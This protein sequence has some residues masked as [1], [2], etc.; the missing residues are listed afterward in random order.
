MPKTKAE[1]ENNLPQQIIAEDTGAS[2]AGKDQKGGAVYIEN[3]ASYVMRGGTIAGMTKT[4]GGAVYIASGSTFTMEAGTITGCQAKYGGAIYVA[5]GGTCNINGGTIS[6]N[7]A[8]VGP[9][10]YVEN[11]G[12]LNVSEEAVIENNEYA[13][14][15]VVSSDTI[16]VGNPSAN[17]NL[18]YIDFGSYPQTYV[19]SSMNTTL[20][21]WYNSNS[22]TAVNTYT[23]R[24]RTWQAYQYTDGNIYA[25]GNR[26]VYESGYTY[27][28]GETV[29]TSST[30]EYTWFKVEP[31]RWIVLNYEAYKS[32]SDSE[33]EIM[34]YL[35]LTADIRFNASSTD[36][37]GTAGTS[38]DP[39]QWVNSELRTWLNS[40]F[41]TSAFTND[42]QELIST[43]TVGN[44]VTN[45]Y[46]TATSN[47]AGVATEDKV[48]CLSYWDYYNSAGLFTNTNGKRLCS[49]TDFALGNYCYKYMSTS[50][51]T[52]TYPSGGTCRCWT[53]SAGSS[54]SDALSVN[55]SGNLFNYTVYY[56][57]YGV[58][59]VL[60]LSI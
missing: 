20:E 55:F 38:D 24:T 46:D 48:Y 2:S 34:S 11:G 29:G 31:I 15:L 30:T 59:P 25:R 44:N 8:E 22:P 13:K 18:P 40:T 6:G 43:T 58:R 5:S 41:Y 42:E 4:Y 35:A 21:S 36:A 26:Y 27:L 57:S 54:A 28:N 12:T 7:F 23:V 53:R 45:N 49:P 17:F 47:T 16:V 33:L 32:G 50:Y 60:R 56:T 51:V 52:A 3:G 37:D 9:A 19:G 10:I 14:Y 1:K 39:N